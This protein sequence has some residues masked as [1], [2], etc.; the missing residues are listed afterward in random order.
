VRAITAAVRAASYRE[1]H[2]YQIS[3]CLLYLDRYGDPADVPL[4]Q[5]LAVRL[6]AAQNARGGW[7]YDCG[8]LPAGEEQRLRARL[9]GRELVAGGVGPGAAAP[10]APAAKGRPGLPGGA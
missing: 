1:T 8:E 9:E 2:T 3:L 6:L 10:G 4:I 5:M 7:T